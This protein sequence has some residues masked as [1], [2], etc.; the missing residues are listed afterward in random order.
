MKNLFN[1]DNPFFTFLSGVADM[2]ILNALF[3]ICSLP[4]F[5]IGA[6]FTA[7][8]YVTL[9]KAEGAD[10]YIARGFFYSF[11][12]NF[13]QATLIWLMMMA[14]MLILWA[15]FRITGSMSGTAVT[16]LRGLLYLAFI[17][18]IM[19]FL[20]VFPILA[21]FS[22]TVMGTLKNGAMAAF[23][24]APKALFTIVVII[25][26]VAVTMWNQNTLVWGLL[27]WILCGFAVLAYI[28]S[29]MQRK[30]IR[31]MMPPEEEEEPVSD[32]DWRAP[33]LPADA[34]RPDPP[35]EN[36]APNASED[37]LTS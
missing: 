35:R 33:D 32:M 20:Y 25:A 18:W 16:V 5:T 34:L 12:Q 8:S 36:A 14:M 11:K 17:I 22:N 28:N 7:M 21:R 2:M 23:A 6:S 29:L 9:K 27:V 26:T 4:V 13:R 37:D 31:R 15:D 1:L 3:I 19:V 24:N 30:L 10:V